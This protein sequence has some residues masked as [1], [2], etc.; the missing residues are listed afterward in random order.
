MR[1]RTGP[2]VVALVMLTVAA[3]LAG[4]A[5]LTRGEDG[6]TPAPVMP[7]GRPASRS[8]VVVL[9]ME[10]KERSQV[11]GTD[12]ARYLTGLDTRAARRS[13]ATGSATRRCRTMWR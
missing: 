13:A 3:A 12:A 10:N 5:V 7:T 6:T 1:H 9:L 8:H 4:V 11:A 2:G